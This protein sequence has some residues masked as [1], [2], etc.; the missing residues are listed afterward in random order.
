[1]Y[2]D[3]QRKNTPHDHHKAEADDRGAARTHPQHPG[4]IHHHG[5]NPEPFVSGIHVEGYI[6]TLELIG[7]R[8]RDDENDDRFLRVRELDVLLVRDLS[9]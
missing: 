3:R 9:P 4:V 2:T 6:D 5:P 7:R 1:M 8:D